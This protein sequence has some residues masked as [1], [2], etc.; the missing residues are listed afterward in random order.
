MNFEY[1]IQDAVDTMKSALYPAEKAAEA[2]PLLCDRV[3]V[4]AVC[5]IE[6]DAAFILNGYRPSWQ[7]EDARKEPDRGL[8]EYST[9]ASWKSYTSGKIS[10]ETAC[11]R[12]IK[13]LAREAE[14]AARLQFEQL[15]KAARAADLT[16]VEIRVDWTRNNT[17]GYNPHATVYASARTTGKASGCGYDKRSAAVAEALNNDAGAL[18]CLYQLAEKALNDG[19]NP[20]NENGVYSWGSVIA[21]GAGHTVLPYFEGGVGI[22]CHLQLFRLAGFDVLAANEHNRHDFYLL[23]REV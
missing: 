2:F 11:K 10:R 8:K 12:A 14:K 1:F 6:N 17:W 20:I 18:K 13:R 3:L 22:N 9:A 19:K 7:N 5:R 16:E 23:R 21:Y 4:D 15:E